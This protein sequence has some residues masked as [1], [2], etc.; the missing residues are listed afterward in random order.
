MQSFHMSL[1]LSSSTFKVYKWHG[2][3]I[4][5]CK[6]KKKNT[7]DTLTILFDITFDSLKEW[8]GRLDFCEWYGARRRPFIP[9]ACSHFVLAIQEEP[10]CGRKPLERAL[11]PVKQGV[12]LWTILICEWYMG[13]AGRR[14][15][16]RDYC[17]LCCLC[18]HLCK[19]WR[20]AVILASMMACFYL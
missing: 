18:V 8:A 17:L 20:M 13:L 15:E 10:P 1:T 14:G 2:I 3:E 16:G 19:H 9:G 12:P 6:G 11:L 5:E 4:W 7:P